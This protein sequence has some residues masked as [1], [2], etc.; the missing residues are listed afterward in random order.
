LWTTRGEQFE[1]KSKRLAEARELAGQ[2][3]LTPNEAAARG[4]K[5]NKDG[6]RRNV[7]DLLGLTGVEFPD[8]AQ[9][10]PALEAL[11]ADAREQLEI[12][13]VYSGYLHRQ[14][15]D[16]DAFRRDEALPI[17][18]GFDY[19]QLAGLSNELCEKLEQVRPATLG[20]AARIDGMTPAALTLVLAY[21]RNPQ[22]RQAG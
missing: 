17:P 8:V 1:A 16:V 2:L 9:I 21:V 7:V 19:G 4:L 14:Q 18:D 11:H 6:K 13:A 10:W 15:A 3:S 5:V 12:E 22:L 20:Q